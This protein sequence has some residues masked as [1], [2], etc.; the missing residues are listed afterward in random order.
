MQHFSE[1]ALRKVLHVSHVEMQTRLKFALDRLCC[2]DLGLSRG[3][4]NHEDYIVLGSRRRSSALLSVPNPSANEFTLPSAQSAQVKTHKSSSEDNRRGLV[5][6]AA[7]AACLA[8]Q[9]PFRAAPKGRGLA[10][11]PNSLFD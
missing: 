4:R 6:S 10:S 5:S 2:P 1:N 9:F 7:L 3:R 8:S 11:A